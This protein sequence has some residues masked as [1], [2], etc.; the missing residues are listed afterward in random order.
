MP[1]HVHRKLSRHGHRSPCGSSLARAAAIAAGCLL[2]ACGPIVGHAADDPAP[3]SLD[4]GCGPRRL[5]DVKMYDYRLRNSEYFA[6]RQASNLERY[7]LS[8]A[9]KA[10]A[11]KHAP[12]VMSNL[13]FALRHCPN[14]HEAL[15]LLI[16]WELD[17]GSMQS[18]K[19]SNCYLDWARGFVP[20]DETV[21]TLGGA[22]FFKKRQ[23]PMAEAWYRKAIEVAPTSAE[24]NYN[25]GLV[26]FELK[27]Y[28]EA[29]RRAKAAYASGF[30]L[31][32][33]RDKLQKAGYPLDMSATP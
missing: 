27:Q 28:E 30:P 32:G 9:R 16:R 6:G 13:D 7:H 10:V 8:K 14:H 2:L 29:R 17:G 21:L 19:R 5:A 12:S 4:Q 20:D 3:T 15:Q 11:A 22:Y 23:I 1:H 26:L 25:Y 18:Y 24:A 33:L 31:P